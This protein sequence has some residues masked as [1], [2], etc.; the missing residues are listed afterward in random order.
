MGEKAFFSF[1]RAQL[2]VLHDAGFDQVQIS[3]QFNVFRCCIQNTINKYKHLGTYEDSKR[4]G[5]PKKV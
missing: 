4:S 5:C 3:K 2:V 1:V